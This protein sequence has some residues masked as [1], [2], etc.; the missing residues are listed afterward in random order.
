MAIHRSQLFQHPVRTPVC[1]CAT[2]RKPPVTPIHARRCAMTVAANRWT[3]TPPTSSPHSSSAPPA[4]TNT[5]AFGAVHGPE[6]DA[7]TPTTARTPQV[8]QRR[9][10]WGR[11]GQRRASFAHR[12][13]TAAPRVPL[14]NGTWTRPRLHRQ[15]C[16]HHPPP[17]RIPKTRQAPFSLGIRSGCYAGNSA[18]LATLSMMLISSSGR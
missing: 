12:L 2:C 1:R 4:E 13:R 9:R 6:P 7:G 5:P 17:T 8:R 14:Q 10:R 11:G 16:Q 18:G 15:H 3:V